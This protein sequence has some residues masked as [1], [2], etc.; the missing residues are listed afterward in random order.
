MAL[1]LK[2]DGYPADCPECKAG[3]HGN[4]DGTAMDINDDLVPCACASRGH[5]GEEE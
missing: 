1:T 3:K 4:C 5:D 2:M